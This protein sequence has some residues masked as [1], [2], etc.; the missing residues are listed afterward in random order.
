[1]RYSSLDIADIISADMKSFYQKIYANLLDYYKLVHYKSSVFSLIYSRLFDVSPHGFRIHGKLMRFLG[2]PV[3]P[4]LSS[5]K[6]AISVWH[7]LF[8][9]PHRPS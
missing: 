7:L 5:Q 9:L 6:P 1:M 3:G 2:I 4:W 8:G